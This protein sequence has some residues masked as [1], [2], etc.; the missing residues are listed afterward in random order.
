MGFL[1]GDI[2]TAQ[3]LNWLTPVI[4]GAQAS[5][6]VG[7]SSTNVDIPGTTLSPTT[8]NA[9]ALIKVFWYAAFYTAAGSLLGALNTARAVIDGVGTVTF[10][11]AGP[12]AS[13]AAGKQQ[14]AA[15]VVTTLA[16]SGAHT[17]KLQATTGA[18]VTLQI[19]SGLDIEIIEAF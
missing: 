5:G 14:G 11:I 8:S 2:I 4:L 1:A 9:G 13:G 15:S 16:A 19:Y 18:G 12:D 10:A 17:I 3:K 7:P 6:T